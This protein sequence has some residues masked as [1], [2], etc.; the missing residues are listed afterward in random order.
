MLNS[1]CACNPEV[2]FRRGYEICLALNV[3]LQL[4]R[5]EQVQKRKMQSKLSLSGSKFTDL[6]YLLNAGQLQHVIF[7]LLEV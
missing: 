7:I 3:P 4:T 5:I 6:D 1:V 2:R